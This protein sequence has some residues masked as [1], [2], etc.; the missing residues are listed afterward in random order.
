MKKYLRW[1]WLALIGQREY[2]FTW[3]GNL[4]APTGAV[5]TILGMTNDAFSWKPGM[6]VRVAPYKYKGA[7][8][9]RLWKLDY[10]G[11]S[12]YAFYGNPEAKLPIRMCRRGLL[13]R[14]FHVPRRLY[15]KVLS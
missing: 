3:A 7:W 15:I 8:E 4:L 10:E 1:L 6:R 2:M 9:V 11:R 12:L 13:K 5:T 14:F